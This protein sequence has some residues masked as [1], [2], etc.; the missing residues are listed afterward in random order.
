MSTEDYIQ[1][2]IAIEWEMFDLVEKRA[3]ELPARMIT[4]HLLLCVQVSTDVGMR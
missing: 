2:I 4:A 1:G 3:E